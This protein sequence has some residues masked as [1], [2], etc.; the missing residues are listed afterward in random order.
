MDGGDGSTRARPDVPEALGARPIRDTLIGWCRRL[1]GGSESISA[2]RTAPS[3]SPTNPAL[4]ISRSF[5]AHTACGPRFRRS[6]ISSRRYL[7]SETKGR[8]IQSLKAYLADRTFEGT[9]IG[10]RHYALEKLIALISMMAPFCARTCR[11]GH[12][13]V[14]VEILIL[15]ECD[16]EPARRLAS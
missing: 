12:E 1:P 6:C 11:S 3:P 2:R 9:A 7:G 13:S 14:S 10:A 16:S 4:P 5:R 15:V 8:F